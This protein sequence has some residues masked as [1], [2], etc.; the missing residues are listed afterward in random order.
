MTTLPRDVRDPSGESP[1]PAARLRIEVRPDGMVA[2][3]G[4]IDE[5]AQLPDLLRHV[6]D[7]RL[8]LDLAGI[9]FINSLGVRDWIRLLAA[10]TQAGVTVELTSVVEPI[11]HQLN[12][13]IAARG[14]AVVRS[15]FAPYAC[16]ACGHEDALLVDVA[17]N[18]PLLQ[19]GVLPALAC[20]TC[21]GAMAF[22]DFP[23]RYLGFL[24]PS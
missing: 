9:T 20:P 21:G 6:R 12:M 14:T 24:T 22:D 19:R 2:L 3:A 4:I 13:I 10:A 1:A 7:R 17:S 11:V 16:D 23:E 5:L 8:G 15:F 18:A